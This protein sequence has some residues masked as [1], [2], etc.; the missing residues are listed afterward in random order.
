[1]PDTD[2]LGDIFDHGTSFIITIRAELAI[3]TS[4]VLWSVNRDYHKATRAILHVTVSL[5]CGGGLESITNYFIEA[6]ADTVLNCSLSWHPADG[7]SSGP[8]AR[9]LELPGVCNHLRYNAVV[10]S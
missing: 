9:P 6:S 3:L 8:P 7:T 1:V 4:A 10:Y 2:Y 5:N